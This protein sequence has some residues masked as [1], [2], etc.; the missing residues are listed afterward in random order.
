MTK[1]YLII[2]LMLTFFLMLL[3]ACSPLENSIE[4][5]CI[6]TT[7]FVS[8]KVTIIDSTGVP[9][10]SLNIVVKDKA[11]NILNVQQDDNN[12]MPGHYTVL[13]DGFLKL[14][15]GQILPQRFDFSADDGKKSVSARYY[16]LTG[17]CCCHINK[18]AG[19]DTLVIR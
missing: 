15:C 14:L 1:K 19:P 13:N 10:D 4:S 3:G 6:C 11:G 7:E 8:S 12:F 17:D 2:S 5:N 16:F 9:V 18:V